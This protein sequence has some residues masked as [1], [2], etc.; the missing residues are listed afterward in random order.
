MAA[1]GVT[2][3]FSRRSLLAAA[4]GTVATLLLPG[5]GSTAASADTTSTAG[6][7]ATATATATTAAQS[8]L[9]GTAFY[10]DP[11]SDA[12]VQVQEWLAAGNTADAAQLQPVAGTPV[13]TWFSG[14]HADPGA[15]AAELTAAATAAGQVAVIVAYDVPGRDAGS[16]SAGGAA[17]AD[18][19]L[20]WVGAIG[21][22][23]GDA[24]AVVIL[25]PDAIAHALDGSNTSL[26]AAEC[27]ALLSSAVDVL[28]QQPNVLVYVDA[29]NSDWVVDTSALATALL[30]SG[31]RRAD[32][33]ALNVSNYQ[34]TEDSLAYG[35]ELSDLL[36]G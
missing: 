29:G 4:G 22:G 28:K 12:A 17:D 27:Y 21:A 5:C 2:H 7:T 13:A 30:A 3:R 33:F 18:T 34:T 23:I 10:V 35:E 31:V 8:P 20:A 15:A 1:R 36:G 19:Y 9:A 24:E 25:E 16:Y 6:S 11:A 14:Q 32:G 26:T